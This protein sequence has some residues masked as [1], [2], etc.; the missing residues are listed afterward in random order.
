MKKILLLGDTHG[1]VENDIVNHFKDADEIWHT[2]DW[3][4]LE[5]LSLMHK[6][7]KTIRGVWGN[8]DSQDCKTQF[9]LHNKFI[10]EGL[11]VWITHIGGFPG[12]YNPKIKEELRANPPDLFICGHS[13]ILK[14]MRDKNLNNM[15][16][17]NPGAAGRHGFHLMR[18]M[19]RFRIDAGKLL[20]LEVIE[21]GKRTAN[22]E[23]EK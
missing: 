12:K 16:H 9:P 13:H 3:L 17:L 10:C 1:C 2:G 14:V 4:T 22:I 20:N 11:K 23:P 19:L 5:L 6:S 21:L 15:I 18:T 8:V 7:G